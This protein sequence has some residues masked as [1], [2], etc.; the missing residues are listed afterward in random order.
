LSTASAHAATPQRSKTEGMPS[1][2]MLP[3]CNRDYQLFLPLLPG[4]D[5]VRT[6]SGRYLRPYLEMPA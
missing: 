4:D 3:L 2:C 5:R 1:T 6:M